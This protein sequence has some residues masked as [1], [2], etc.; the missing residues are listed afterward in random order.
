MIKFEWNEAKA[1]SNQVKHGISF[2]EAKTAFF[3]ER[4]LQ[5]FDETNSILDEDRFLLLGMSNSSKLLLICH[6]ERKDGEV[7]RIISARKAT[8]SE[9]KLY[10]DL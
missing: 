8:K 5:F 2:K 7:I 4:A 10:G 3:D 6:C 1:A 9:S